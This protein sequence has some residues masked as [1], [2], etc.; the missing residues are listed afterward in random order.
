MNSGRCVWTA[1][2]GCP[3]MS[4]PTSGTRM[5]VQAGTTGSCG[6]RRLERQPPRAVRFHDDHVG[7]ARGRDPVYDLRR[8]ALQLLAVR[9]RS[10][11]RQARGDARPIASGSAA[12]SDLSSSSS[13]LAGARS[14]CPTK[15]LVVIVVTTVRP[16]AVSSSARRNMTVVLPPPP[17]SVTTS[18]RRIRNA[19][20][21]STPGSVSALASFVLTPPRP[22]ACRPVYQGRSPFG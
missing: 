6:G 11:R 1:S 20:L 14:I 15:I 4:S 21:I 2:S 7:H 19:S 8:H 3:S 16:A 13:R 5:D 9:A 10:A 18:P 17:T 12:N 22:T